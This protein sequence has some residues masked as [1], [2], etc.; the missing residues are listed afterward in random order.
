MCPC[1]RATM[2]ERDVTR[3]RANTLRLALSG[4]LGPDAFASDD[5]METLKLCVSCKACRRECPTGVDMAKMKIEVLAARAAKHGLSLRDR[6]IAFLPRYAPI[7][8]R[9]CRLANL[10]DDDAGLAH[11]SETICRLE[12]AARACRAGAATCREPDE[13]S[14]A[15]RQGD[16]PRGRALRRHVQ[17]LFRA[18]EHRRRARRARG[19]WLS[20]ASAEARGRQ[21]RRSAADAR[22][23]SFGLVERGAARSRRTVAALVPFVARG[24]PIVGLEPSCSSPSATSSGADHARR[25]ATPR[26]ASDAVRGIPRA[27]G[28]GGHG[29]ICRS[30]VAK[31]LLHGH[32]HQKSFAAMGAV[33]KVLKLVPALAVETVELS[34]CGMAGASAT[35]PR[36]S[37]CRSRWRSSRCCPPCARPPADTLIVADGTSCRHRSRTARREA[38]HVARVLARG[39]HA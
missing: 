30:T 28:D 15:R 7:A 11:C 23:S 25:R 10:R 6:L 12:R 33:E 17:P 3:G 5:M 29:S 20:R 13:L 32:C 26:R 19:R 21:R 37:T 35:A 31:A 14:S 24:V 36:R 8:A 18:G 22:S 38:L 2:N 16:G 39:R 1:Y 9:A 4:Q 34:C 27:R